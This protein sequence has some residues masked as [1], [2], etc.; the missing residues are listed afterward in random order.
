MF[1]LPVIPLVKK[2]KENNYTDEQKIT[3][4]CLSEYMVE[5]IYYDDFP[6]T[7]NEPVKLK[8]I[9]NSDWIDDNYI[10]WDY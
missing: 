5:D 2:Y 6:Y 1:E 4:K 3:M 8:K 9:R 7:K 10:V